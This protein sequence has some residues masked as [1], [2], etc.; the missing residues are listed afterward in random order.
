M[1]VNDNETPKKICSY[2]KK[3]TFCLQVCRVSAIS[4]RC[5]GKPPTVSCNNIW[6]LHEEM[7]HHLCRCITVCRSTDVVAYL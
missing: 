7:P 2:S 1:N 5:R 3:M 6:A 4:G